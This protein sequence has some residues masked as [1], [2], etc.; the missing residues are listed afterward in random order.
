M[1]LQSL[2]Y[3]KKNWI[4]YNQPE[5]QQQTPILPVIYITCCI[6]LK[7]IQG[8]GSQQLYYHDC[9]G[10][11]PGH[12][13]GRVRTGDQLLPVP[14]WTRHPNVAFG[15]KY[16]TSYMQS[17]STSYHQVQNISYMTKL[18]LCTTVQSL[19]T[20]LQHVVHNVIQYIIVRYKTYHILL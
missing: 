13:T 8:G 14:T 6:F 1:S 16:I 11:I 17:Y 20:P 9:S 7:H 5:L 15:K 19:E 4:M 10:R 3:V 2:A 18:L 12:T